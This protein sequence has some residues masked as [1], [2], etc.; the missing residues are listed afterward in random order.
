MPI[1]PIGQALLRSTASE[2]TQLQQ[3]L[4]EVDPNDPQAIMQLQQQIA[5]LKDTVAEVEKQPGPPGQ[6]ATIHMGAVTTLP[7]GSTATADMVDGQLNLGI[8]EGEPG[9]DAVLELGS[10]TVGSQASAE[11]VECRLNLVLPAP[12]DGKDATIAM[13]TLTTLSA[14]SKATASIEGGLLNLGIPAGQPGRD[15]PP[16]QTGTVTTGAPGSPASASIT[17][18]LLN[19]SIPQGVPGNDAVLSLGTVSG[20]TQAAA[21]IVNGKLNLVLPA[22]QDG[23]DATPLAI[24]TITT[25]AA[26]SQASASIVAGKLNLSIPQGANGQDA[27]I[28]IGMVSSGTQ[29]A[30][31]ISAG[32]LN[33]T[34]PKGDTGPQGLTTISAPTA[35]SPLP[36]LGSA[37]QVAKTSYLSLVVEAAYTVTLASTMEDVIELRVGTDANVGAATNPSGV[38]VA[39]WRASFTGIGVMIGAGMV[40]RAQLT[41]IVPGS[42]YWALRRTT[43]TRATVVSGSLQQLVP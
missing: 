12:A 31:S 6:N 13:G 26:G 25:G 19:L 34:L 39:S 17:D 35:L 28:A 33:L 3:Q 2:L 43:G 29:A 22:G 5:A 42:M 4:A 23:K 18:G 41:A 10:V 8:P 27:T 40:D 20:G 16:L 24:G 14:G 37:Y 36:A 32:K 9:Q 21:S 38:V 30:A 1:T 15:A 7:P 11:I